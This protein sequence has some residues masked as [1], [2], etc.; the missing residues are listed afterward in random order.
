MKSGR[1][2]GDEEGKWDQL[3]RT[4]AVIMELY[5]ISRSLDRVVWK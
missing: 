4:L 2:W 3:Q 5:I 1:R